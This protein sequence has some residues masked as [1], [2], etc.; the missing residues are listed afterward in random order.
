MYK[1][2]ISLFLFLQFIF[3][4]LISAQTITDMGDSISV[5]GNKYL[6]TI[7]KQTAEVKL[8][9]NTGLQYTKFPLTA[10]ATKAFST[11]NLKYLWE[12][13][14]SEIG[15]TAEDT[16]AEKDVFKANI[17]CYTDNFEVQF[18]VLVS[19]ENIGQVSYSQDW[20]ILGLDISVDQN[21][22]TI[23]GNQYPKGLGT[24]ANS[25]IIIQLGEPYL[26]FL[27][28]V[29]VDDEVG[30][31]GSVVFQVFTDDSKVY[32]SGI[33]EGSDSSE[34]VEVSL[35]NVKELKLI[36]TNGGDN[37]HYDH[38]D[39]ALARLVKNNG[40]TIY[41]SDW[42]RSLREQVNIFCSDKGSIDTD[43]WIKMFTP[44]PDIFYYDNEVGVDLLKNRDNKRYYA[45]A[46]LNI[47]FLTPAGWFSVGLC[48]LPD[49]NCFIFKDN[50]FF[51]DYTWSKMDLSPKN[52]YWI[53]PL[54]FTF[55]EDEWQGI[56]DYRN[57]LVNKEYII[58]PSIDER[59][60]P[61]WWMEPLVCTWGEQLARGVAC[62]ASGFNCNWVEN[63]VN[64]QED[65]LGYNTF[66]LI[67]DDKWQK[68]Y[69]DPNPDPDR[70]KHLRSLIDDLHSKGHHVM[71]WWMCWHGESGSL[72]E[73]MGITDNGLID[74]THLDFVNYVQQS[75]YKMLSSDP[76]CLNADG[77]KMDYI[78]DLRNPAMAEDY[79]DPSKGIGLRE[80]YRYIKTWYDEA[81][82][83]KPECLITF[84]G[85]DPHFAAVQ[86]MN[87][88]NDGD[89]THSTTNWQNRARISSLST[90]N[91]LI[92]G[93]GWTMY[94]D[95]IFPHLI[96]SSVYSTPSLYHLTKYSDDQK[97]TDE[98]LQLMGNIFSLASM[99]RPGKAVY[100]DN[101]CWQMIDEQG[102]IAESM[103]NSSSLIVYPDSANGYALTVLNQSLIIPLH[104]RNVI[105]VLADTQKIIFIIEGDNLKIPSAVKG[106]IYNIKFCGSTF[107]NDNDFDRLEK[108]GLYQNY[109]NPFN[110]E[111]LIN[112][113]IGG[114]DSEPVNID[115]YNI[116]GQQVKA[117]VKETKPPGKY[118]IN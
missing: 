74:A 45:P 78:F 20:G 102:L 13:A 67:L 82:K 115:I 15:L 85:P 12:T 51:I 22:L 118:K 87:R 91:I 46:P 18:S 80:L 39:W 99:K 14:G 65:K 81:K 93:D 86:D 26:E 19:T 36:V 92:D 25:E 50:Y 21:T 47:S 2:Q 37:I 79:A 11:S 101:N 73:Q 68:Y 98:E 103:Q 31:N 60:I 66:T 54:C 104:N 56:T 76:G 114:T 55:N 75:I 89:G 27:S 52:I 28:E 105:K 95:L 49:A 90:P 57:Y 71:L 61:Q 88:L 32:D 44:E 109:P 53:T 42:I 108:C 100:K 107:I 84:S 3:Y 48:E 64:D 8:K 62:G 29:G 69:G 10:Y 77:F 112:Y 35:Q 72:P 97:I 7:Q 113:S 34:V 59:K 33:L 110:P 63:Y 5:T 117:L 4:S 116:L 96:T 94:N 43:G 41:I 38:A 40:D 58:D 23:G 83:V 70:F 6:L 17:K 111:T 30:N 106:Q 9:N 1:L 16:T 24:H